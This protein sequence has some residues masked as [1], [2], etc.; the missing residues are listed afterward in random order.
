M[1]KFSSFDGLHM[2]SYVNILDKF[3]LKIW[4]I[5]YHDASHKLI[6]SQIFWVPDEKFIFQLLDF[7]FHNCLIILFSSLKYKIWN[8]RVDKRPETSSRGRK[9]ISVWKTDQQINL[10]TRIFNHTLCVRCLIKN[11]SSFCSIYC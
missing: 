5:L 4:H 6:N 9:I 8:S 1:N 3:S 11:F 2:T 10:W 7:R